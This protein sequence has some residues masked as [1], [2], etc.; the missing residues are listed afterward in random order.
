MAVSTNIKYASLDELYL[1]PINPRLGRHNSDP[2]LVQE[3]IRKIMRVW[4]LEELAVSFLEGGGF[5][6]HEA[7]LVVKEKLYGAE[8]LVVIEGNR[9]L[10]ALWYLEDAIDGAPASKSWKEL[11]KSPKAGRKLFSD[12]PYFL[13]GSRKEVEAFIGFRHVTGIKEW[14]PAEKAEY[15]A[16]RIDESKWSYDEARRKIG[17]KAPTIRQHYISYRLLLQIE[18][19]VDGFP[20]KKLAERFSVMYLSLRTKGVQRFLQVDMLAEPRKVKKPVPRK[21]LRNLADFALWLFGDG[22]HSPLFTDSRR[23][24]EFGWILESKKAVEYLR[25]SDKP[26][27]DAAYRIAGG[28]EHE[29]VR[30]VERAADNIEFALARAHSYT[31]SKPL[32][33]AIARMGDDAFQILS[34]FPD[35]REKLLEKHESGEQV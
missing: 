10:A 7:L 4:R 5:W 34:I 17:S 3:D 14:K 11:A 15:I 8:H 31:K 32:Q 33:K 25:R 35:I 2:K 9:R 19:S 16:K 12:I 18:D 13:V 30:Y 6:T 24:D 29:I 28:D 1:D 20:A 27:F 22:N 21:A 26:S 23:I